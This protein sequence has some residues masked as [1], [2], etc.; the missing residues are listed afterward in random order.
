ME[1]SPVRMQYADRSAAS[2]LPASGRGAAQATDA[3]PAG[4][5]PATARE[6]SE[7]EQAYNALKTI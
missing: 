6:A 1:R 4:A 3:A 7:L 2:W 5:K